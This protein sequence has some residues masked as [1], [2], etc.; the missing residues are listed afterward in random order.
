MIDTRLTISKNL[1]ALRAMQAFGPATVSKMMEAATEDA[2]LPIYVKETPKNFGKFAQ[3]L[4]VKKVAQLQYD[5]VSTAKA[6]GVNYPLLL[7]QGTGKM[8]G[9][10]D[11]GYTPGHV[12]A[13]TVAYG[14]GGIRPN[15]A[16]QRAT[17]IAKMPTVRSFNKLIKENL[18]AH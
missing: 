18:H 9:R 5:V 4:R 1:P 13:K 7:A 15:K 10:R 14:I 17:K 6:G 8:R 16:A 12:R 3:G 2:T 11:F